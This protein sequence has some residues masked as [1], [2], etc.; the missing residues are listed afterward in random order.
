[1]T[2]FWIGIIVFAL[3][4]II[5]Y[6]LKLKIHSRFK[7]MSIT[8]KRKELINKKYRTMVYISL[9][10]QVIGCIISIFSIWE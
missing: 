9:G 3:G 8:D 10:I 5:R 6:I 1:M 7:N 2:L 4:A